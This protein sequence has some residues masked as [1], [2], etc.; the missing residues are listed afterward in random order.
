MNQYFLFLILGL[1]TGAVY[2]ALTLGIV[3]TYQGTGVINFAAGSMVTVPL[4]VYDDLR[5]GLFTLPLPWI[6]SVHVGKLPTWTAVLASL[7]IAA[8][9]GAVIEVAVS[10]P[11]RGA[12]VLAKVVG[13]VG[14]MLTLQAAMALKYGSTPRPLQTVLPSGSTRI[15]GVSAATD[16]L[17]LIGI[18]VVLGAALAIWFRRSRAGLAVQAASENGRAA[19]FARLSPNRL[20]ML[21]WTL[22]TVFSTLILVLAGPAIGV[23]NPS[24]LT[25]LVVPALAGALL[26]RLSS[27]WLGLIG[28]LAL[29]VVNSELQ[30]MSQTKAWWPSWAKQGL[31]DAVPFL[32]VVVALFLL[33]RSIPARGDENRLALP[34]VLLPRNR[35]FV[36]ALLSIGGV[37]AVVLSSGTYRFGVITSLAESLIALSLVLL[38]GMLGQISLAQAAFAGLAGLTV[39]KFGTHIPFPLSVVL[40]ALVAAAV[41][42]I[43]GLP[44]LRIRGAQLAVVTL[45]AGL[46]LQ[47]FVFNN[48]SIMSSTA[49]LIPDPKL[50]GW[51]LGVRSGGDIARVQFGLTVLVIVIIMFVLMANLVRGGTG[52][53]MIAV[54]SNER[55][56]ASIGIN[57]AGLKL[58]TFAISSFLAGLG[59][60]LI[61]YSQGQLS[62]ASFS[63][64]VGLA[65]LASAYVGGIASLSGAFIAGAIASVGVV[66]VFLDSTL[67][68]GDYFPLITGLSLVVTV[69]LNPVG[70]AG[71]TR[72][73]SERIVA[74]WKSR[75]G[76]AAVLAPAD[77]GAPML[78]IKAAPMPARGER[79]VGDVL[80]RTEGI[81]VSYGG[82]RAVDGVSIEVRAGEIVGLIGPNGAGKTSF[83][84]AI[85]GFAPCRGDVY[86]KGEKVST[87]TAYRRARR[88]LVRSWQSGEL[89]SD[90]SVRSNVR[91]ADD[92]GRDIR[93]LFKDMVRP[94]S[95]PSNAVTDAMGL[96]S[97][98]DV[99]ERKP[100]DLS[101]GRQKTLGVARALALRPS[102]LLLDEPAA[103][104][105]SIE[106]LEFGA[107][108]ERIA[109]TGV[110]CLLV[111]HDMSLVLGVCDR[112]YVID[113]GR[114]IAH[115]KPEEVR[116]DPRV[117]AA[118]LG[119]ESITAITR[120]LAE[121]NAAVGSDNSIALRQGHGR[122]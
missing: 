49:D 6:P 110:G 54:R 42:V 30:F 116:K 100:S 93:R 72:E 111:D 53:K 46:A 102:V 52:R 106:S 99:S 86:L 118:Y 13:A 122:A 119:S 85:T 113:F 109:R 105:D 91:V 41:G 67:H 17:W 65:L 81:T 70:I 22:A 47:S 3:V 75:P 89:F 27:L 84:D 25:L 63:V 80:L 58:E 108:L 87:L 79:Q 59:G 35:P 32:V 38:T 97:L 23:L 44:A 95:G 104:L 7:V 12:P 98:N 90:L 48:P 26:G 101:L 37:L 51:N 69:V 11:L 15:A 33:G 21:T 114:Q 82:L 62:A 29:G 73:Q 68:V 71:K 88:G 103:G 9:V 77:G 36:I 28:A 107:D 115:G 78:G 31:T 16:R 50:F 43:V 83:I 10:R 18:T 121:R 19:A 56:A 60:A 14:V 92:V 40:A 8:L 45:A 1:G 24:N 74:Y 94:S 55:A 112:I 39:S 76:N 66:F 4:F 5:N 96:M 64:P 120:D 2:A 61:G 20:G 57:V 34:P 117:V